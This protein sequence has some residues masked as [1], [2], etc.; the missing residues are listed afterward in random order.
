VSDESVA[1]EPVS[2][3]GSNRGG[4]PNLFRGPLMLRTL[5]TR[6]VVAYGGDQAYIVGTAK[7]PSGNSG[8]LSKVL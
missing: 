7:I 6:R 2:G 1:R 8:D 4:K 3:L 5:H